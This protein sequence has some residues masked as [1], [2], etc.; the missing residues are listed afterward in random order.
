MKPCLRHATLALTASLACAGSAMATASSSASVDQL[1]FQVIDLDPTDGV[2]ASVSFIYNDPNG[3]CQIG[4]AACPNFTGVQLYETSTNSFAQQ[5]TGRGTVL[6]PN[7]GTLSLAFGSA[8]ASI[9]ATPNT[10]S[11]TASGS[12]RGSLSA[13]D[14]LASGNYYAN[15]QVLG[16]DESVSFTLSRNTLL[17]ITGT[18][19]VSASTTD[20]GSIRDPNY[21]DS[22]AERAN[23]AVELHFAAP[24]ATGTKNGTP[25]V[26]YSLYSFATFGSS[27][28][29]TQAISA[30]Y[31]N[32]GAQDLN[33]T[34][35]L[36]AT[37]EGFSYVP[38]VPEP[39]SWALLGAGLAL[40]TGVARRRR[41]AG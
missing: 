20:G 39:S 23:A 25:Y 41:A 18:A 33:G 17:V 15:A 6:S 1:L 10:L 12:A 34:L 19:S 30:W 22:P 35:Q 14:P 7:T 26:D 40:V 24:G 9:A 37:A 5:Q 16:G 28:T 29:Q 2:A 21:S 11:L 8:L 31:A 4:P 38:A 27:N 32:T 36:L 3:R 13:T